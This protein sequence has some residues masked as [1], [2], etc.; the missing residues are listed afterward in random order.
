MR[1]VAAPSHVVLFLQGD[2]VAVNVQVDRAVHVDDLRP[3]I[4]DLFFLVL[5]VVLTAVVIPAAVLFLAQGIDQLRA[6]ID[7]VDAA[8]GSTAAAGDAPVDRGPAVRAAQRRL[9]IGR[10]SAVPARVV[11]VVRPGRT[12][13]RSHSDRDQQ[14]PSEMIH[15]ASSRAFPLRRSVGLLLY[16]K[17][18]I[19]TARSSIVFAVRDAGFI[20]S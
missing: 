2:K 13:R 3:M 19:A 1:R 14:L 17:Y 5:V 9:R 8:A 20:R 16:G 15:H 10:R 6:V 4:E 11:I 12:Q 18:S 7:M